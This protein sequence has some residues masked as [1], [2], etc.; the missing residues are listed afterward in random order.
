MHSCV[1]YFPSLFFRRGSPRRSRRLWCNDV[2][3]MLAAWMDELPDLIGPIN[4]D[5]KTPAQVDGSPTLADWDG[6]TIDL[7]EQLPTP[8]DHEVPLQ[9][10]EPPQIRNLGPT[11]G[12]FVAENSDPPVVLPGTSD[13][14]QVASFKL[15]GY[16][17]CGLDMLPPSV[18]QQIRSQQWCMP[19]LNWPHPW[20]LPPPSPFM[21]ASAWPVPPRP[22]SRHA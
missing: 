3:K 6:E 19:Q 4:Q 8:T 20:G 12:G 10:S 14:G 18:Q 9:P 21:Q 16:V 13:T 17:I 5:D 11:E 7:D 22:D 1:F 2:D 15:V